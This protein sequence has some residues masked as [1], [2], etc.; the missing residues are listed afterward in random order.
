M[1]GETSQ[2]SKGAMALIIEDDPL[3]VWCLKRHLAASF[4]TRVVKTL[5]EARAH[6]NDPRLRVIIC[7][8]PIV[9]HDLEALEALSHQP[10]CAVIALVSD[11]SRAVPPGV[12]AVEKPFA[13][14]QLSKVLSTSADNTEV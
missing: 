6:L 14:E 3:T 8:S 12:R 9:D 7:G 11:T 4:D 1:C 5:A 13:L 2:D 10:G